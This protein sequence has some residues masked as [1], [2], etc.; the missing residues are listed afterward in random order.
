[1]R[2][3]L[4]TA[5]A[6]AV[7]ALA[8]TGSIASVTVAAGPAAN[9]PAAKGLAAHQQASARDLTPDAELFQAT[10]RFTEWELV[11]K[12]P[13]D[14][15]T[16]HPQGM[17]VVGERIY[18]SSVEIIEP[19]VKYEE[20]V[21]GMDRTAGVGKGHVFVLT[22]EGELVKD[23]ELGEGDVYHPGGVDFD[24]EKLWVPVAE[25]RPDSASIVYT[26]DPETLEVTDEFRHADHVGGVV[27]DQQ[28][29][30]IHGVSWGS[31]DFFAW[32][33][34]GKLKDE[35]QNPSHFIDYQDCDYSG[36]RTQLCYGITNLSNDAGQ[37]F[38]LGGIA[39]T[40]L[41]THEIVHEVPVPMVSTAGH[42]I[43]RNPAALEA[44]GDVLR[45]FAAP[46]DGEEDAGT[47][48]F[49]YEARP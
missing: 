17:A 30:Q 25:Y 16:Y 27:R 5:S 49:V 7:A 11:E 6:L 48:L 3:S 42:T 12:L 13:L 26:I 31:R 41:R 4:P 10:T 15:E 32:N 37:S 36:G 46:D 33:Q 21:D 24:G 2:L 35:S 23:I 40:D 34:H 44:D 38:E 14:F 45:L 1:M 39:L 47:E 28:T 22:R 18:L 8:V 9:G 43:T 29:G 19:T 20:P